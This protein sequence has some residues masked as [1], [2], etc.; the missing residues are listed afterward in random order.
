M[1]NNTL[2]KNKELYQT[3]VT[4]LNYLLTW[5]CSVT[6]NRQLGSGSGSGSG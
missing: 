5:S 4:Y 3:Q 1:H 6:S 2:K